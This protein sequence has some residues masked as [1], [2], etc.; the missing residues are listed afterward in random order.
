VG[1][2][3]TSGLRI[4]RACRRVDGGV[5]RYRLAGPV[6]A[7]LLNFGVQPGKPD[8]LEVSQA[9]ISGRDQEAATFRVILFPAV[10]RA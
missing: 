1:V 2:D 9:G 6:T 10:D 4:E 7:A 3:D 5:Q 8:W